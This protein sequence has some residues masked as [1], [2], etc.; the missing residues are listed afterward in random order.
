[1]IAALVG[2]NILWALGGGANGLLFDRL[3]GV[4][5]AAKEGLQPD[6][7]VSVLYAASGLGLFVGMMLARRIGAHLELHNSTA[8]FMGWAIIVY[9]VLFASIGLMPSLR[10]AALMIFVSHVVLS[11]EFAVHIT[12]L[13]TLL[14]DRLRGRVTITDRAAEILM[15][16]MSMIIAGW[17]LRY[18]SPRTLTIVAGLLSITPGVLW[19]ALFARGVL[20]L[21]Q[22]TLT[23]A[24][25]EHSA[26]DVDLVSAS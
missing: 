16:S 10:L 26:S 3:G 14:P 20:S 2:F 9:G 5:F 23:Q 25:E 4:L 19:L 22:E 15:M 7:G 8:R 13:M 24:E 17:A 18:F 21:P 6:A 1:M 11:V 12:L